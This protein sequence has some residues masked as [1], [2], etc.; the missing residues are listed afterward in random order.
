V[1]KQEEKEEEMCA[2]YEKRHTQLTLSLR[3]HVCFVACVT[4]VFQLTI[5]QQRLY[6]VER[7]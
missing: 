4:K 5:Q 2:A 3:A 7:G 6:D 1:Q